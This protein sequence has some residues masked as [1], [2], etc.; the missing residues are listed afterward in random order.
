MLAPLVNLLGMIQSV[1]RYLFLPLAVF[2]VWLGVRRDFFTA[3]LLLTTVLYY[4]VPGSA[5]HT[6]IRYVLPMHGLLPIFAG[7]R[8]CR[9]AEMALGL[10]RRDIKKEKKLEAES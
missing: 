8:L 9:L 6:E 5:A 1:V 10:K 7:L 2:G 3:A 4:L